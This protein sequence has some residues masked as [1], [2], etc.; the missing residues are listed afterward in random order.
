MRA[1]TGTLS[2][3]GYASKNLHPSGRCT[4]SLHDDEDPETLEVAVAIRHSVGAVVL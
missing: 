1:F 2:R 3:S 4:Q